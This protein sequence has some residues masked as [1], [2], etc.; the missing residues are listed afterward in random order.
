MVVDDEVPK[1]GNIRPPP[2]TADPPPNPSDSAPEHSAPEYQFTN[3]NEQFMSW[4]ELELDQ[5]SSKENFEEINHKNDNSAGLWQKN[6][7]PQHDQRTSDVERAQQEKQH[8]RQQYVLSQLAE[9][10]R[11]NGN[12][13]AE[14][15]ALV[16]KV[17]TDAETASAAL[18]QK[19]IGIGKG[20]GLFYVFGSDVPLSSVRELFDSSPES[21][22]LHPTQTRIP[23]LDIPTRTGCRV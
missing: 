13:D 23:G 3:E 1:I 17:R 7:A 11:K 8:V 19:V 21:R 18:V 22:G 2:P 5:P 15:A 4:G 14:T 12:N 6:V 10:S 9:I 16:Q 20:G